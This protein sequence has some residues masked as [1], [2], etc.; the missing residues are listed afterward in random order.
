VAGRIIAGLAAGETVVFPDDAS[1][2][3][4]SIYLSDPPKLEQMLAGNQG[5]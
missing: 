4:G 5:G 3:A 1:A 2:G